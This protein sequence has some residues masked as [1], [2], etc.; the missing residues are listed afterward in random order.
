M[1]TTLLIPEMNF[2]C[3]ASII[4][5]IVAG[6]NLNSGSHSQIQIWRKNNSQNSVYYKVGSVYVNT[7]NSND[8]VCVAKR[9]VGPTYWCILNDQLLVQPGDI[10]GLEL[11]DNNNEIFFTKGGPENYVFQGQLE[12]D[13]TLSNDNDSSYTYVRQLP[14]ISLNFTSGKIIKL[15]CF[16]VTLPSLHSL[17]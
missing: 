1:V 3:N 11:P 17:I 13:V 8:G 5:F 12:F 9:I 15:L 7:V 6:R 14:Q 4:G 16:I 10:L 2:T